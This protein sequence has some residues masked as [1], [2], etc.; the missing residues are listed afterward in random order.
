M[1]ID[2]EQLKEKIEDDQTKT[3]DQKAKELWRI[4]KVELLFLKYFGIERR[5]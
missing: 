2:T 4:E 5:F 3:K 1:I